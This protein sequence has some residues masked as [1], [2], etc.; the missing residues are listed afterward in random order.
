MLSVTTHVTPQLSSILIF[1]VYFIHKVHQAMVSIAAHHTKDSVVSVKTMQDRL[2]GVMVLLIMILH[3]CDTRYSHVS[4]CF[5]VLLFVPN[6]SLC[7]ATFYVSCCLV[8][9]DSMVFSGVPQPR[10]TQNY[11]LLIIILAKK[12][13]HFLSAG[14]SFYKLLIGLLSLQVVGIFLSG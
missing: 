11:Y 13:R 14:G 5:L 1:Y 6:E 7:T 3:M 10:K 8:L 2:E 12:D 4:S 9:I